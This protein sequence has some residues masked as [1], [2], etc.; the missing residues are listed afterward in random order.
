MLRDGETKK[1]EISIF[2]GYIPGE[3][4]IR[5]ELHYALD[6]IKDRVVMVCNTLARDKQHAVKIANE[7]RA[8]LIASD[9]WKVTES[10]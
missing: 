3:C 8:Q 2:G 1:I 7:K 5:K 10:R 9:Q 6:P 4:H